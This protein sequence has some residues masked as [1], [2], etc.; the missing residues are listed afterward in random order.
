M[1]LGVINESD[2][3]TSGKGGCGFFVRVGV[4][5]GA[6]GFR[7][8]R[9]RGCA[10]AIPIDEFCPGFTVRVSVTVVA[11][12]PFGVRIDPGKPG[13]VFVCGDTG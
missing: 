7:T 11:C 2:A 9:F 1:M 3:S 10:H 8:G 13:T 12:K 5:C 4:C 6:Y